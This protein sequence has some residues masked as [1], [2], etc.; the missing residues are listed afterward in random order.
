MSVAKS[1]S[2]IGLILLMICA[3]LLGKKREVLQHAPLP[4]KVL[5]AKTIYI[6]NDSG[7][8]DMAD[9]AYTQLRAWGKYQIVDAKEKADLI[10]VLS[11]ASAQAEGVTSS[12]ASF[13]N[14]K[15][16]A[17]TQ[18]TVSTP[19]VET[20]YYSRIRLVDAASGDTAWADE[21]AGEKK[22][23][24][25]IELIKA[26]QQRMDEQEESSK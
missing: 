9:K 4:A 7:H 14:Y 26:L 2:L 20:W 21:R 10:L 6:Q 11:I 16:G 18:G 23:S 24:A 25:T 19:N 15:T 17:W 13:Y 5:S 12:H 1:F 22:K 3:P 8:A